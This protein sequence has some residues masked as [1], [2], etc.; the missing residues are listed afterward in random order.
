[1]IIL[2]VTV[3]F[4]R[5]IIQLSDKVHVYVDFFALFYLGSDD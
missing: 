1:M 5:N 3:M 2:T 4:Y